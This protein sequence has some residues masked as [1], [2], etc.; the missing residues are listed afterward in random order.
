MTDPGEVPNADIT[1]DEAD[2]GATESDQDVR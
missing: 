2:A 1:P